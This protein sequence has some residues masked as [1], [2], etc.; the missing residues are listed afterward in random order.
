MKDNWLQYAWKNE[1]RKM[2]R[3][4]SPDKSHNFDPV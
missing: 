2:T 4:Q 1:S 3:I